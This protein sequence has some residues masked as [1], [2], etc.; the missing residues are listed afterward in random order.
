MFLFNYTNKKGEVFNYKL[1]STNHLTVMG[2]MLKFHTGF[3]VVHIDF[4]GDLHAQKA[5]ETIMNSKNK[6]SFKMPGV[7]DADEIAKAKK[8]A[9]SAAANLK[10]IQ[11][12]ETVAEKAKK[13]I[14][15]AKAKAEKEKKE[16]VE[17]DLEKVTAEVKKK[18]SKKSKK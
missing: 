4:A 9:E 13:D 18:P 2:N 10:K 17:A 1:S 16:K 12:E 15:D 14:A 11:D 3:S 7:S 5:Y 8:L 6:V